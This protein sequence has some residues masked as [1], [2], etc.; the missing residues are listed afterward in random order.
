VPS[1][2]IAETSYDPEASIMF[3]KFTTG[4]IYAY[5]NVP[6][7][8]YEELK[9]S[10]SKGNFLNTRIKGHYSYKKIS[11]DNSQWG[12]FSTAGAEQ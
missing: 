8:V 2:V 9:R 12:L 10:R 4:I 3:L 6:A 7:Q 1:T 11:D 5:E